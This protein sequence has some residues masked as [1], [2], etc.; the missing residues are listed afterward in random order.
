MMS[1]T[2]C[3]DIANSSH[4]CPLQ[5]GWSPPLHSWS[6]FKARQWHTCYEPHSCQTWKETYSSAD[7]PTVSNCNILP[8]YTRPD[9]AHQ[10]TYFPAR[11]HQ[12]PMMMSHLLL[13][14]NS[15]CEQ[16]YYHCS[17][18]A[19]TTFLHLAPQSWPTHSRTYNANNTSMQYQWLIPGYHTAATSNAISFNT[20]STIKTFSN[21]LK[22][23][24]L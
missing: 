19:Q 9:T 16:W 6:L 3:A 24:H 17:P 11:N 2:C 14:H 23:E 13:Y 20:S 15:W 8:I 18:Q 7:L 1:A 5:A 21:N 22:P 4:P 10:P 12:Y